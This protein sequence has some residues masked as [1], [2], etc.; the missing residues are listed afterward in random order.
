M[1]YNFKLEDDNIKHP[2]MI[3]QVIKDTRND[4][5]VSKLIPDDLQC[6]INYLDLIVMFR[7][8]W[9]STGY[10]DLG[11]IPVIYGP[12]FMHSY[13]VPSILSRCN[14]AGLKIEPMPGISFFKRN[15]KED[16][17]DYWIFRDEA[18]K[19]LGCSTK[20]VTSKKLLSKLLRRE[21]E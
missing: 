18:A 11:M 8:K 14:E 13:I 17:T 19:Y 10:L 21:F 16:I 12:S 9:I 2:S 4:I 5:S 3:Y 20:E 1:T 6:Y 7:N 15:F